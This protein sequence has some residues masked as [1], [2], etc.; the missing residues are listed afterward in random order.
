MRLL[1]NETNDN[2]KKIPRES[3][4]ESESMH[5]EHLPHLEPIEFSL[6]V[7]LNSFN[8]DNKYYVFKDY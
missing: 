4:C 1:T 5:C 7:S 6:N 3:I 2:I 8:Y